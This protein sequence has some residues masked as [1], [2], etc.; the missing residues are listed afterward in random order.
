VLRGHG[1]QRVRG[2]GCRR[3]E[4]EPLRGT[5]GDEAIQRHL[6]Q[7]RDDL[8]QILPDDG[9][10]LPLGN[11]AD[12]PLPR[13]RHLRHGRP[14]GRDGQRRAVHSPAPPKAARDL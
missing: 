10:D 5:Q 12:Q 2:A 13:K 14:A 11:Q 8:Q 3:V 6:A 7:R 9:H 1:V 4:S